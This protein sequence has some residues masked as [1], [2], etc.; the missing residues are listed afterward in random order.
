MDACNYNKTP[1]T[2]W[3]LWLLS[4][5]ILIQLADGV[6][7]AGFRAHGEYAFH[8]FFSSTTLLLQQLAIWTA[9]F[10]GAG[11][12]FAA[13]YMLIVRIV[14]TSLL[15]ILLFRRHKTLSLGCRHANRRQL[16]NLVK[17]ALANMAI[18]IAQG[19]NIQGMVIIVGTF[20]SPLA[21]V[22]FTTLRT[23]T[24]FALQIVLSI[25]HAF[26]PEMAAAWGRNDKLV[27]V[28]LYVNN[29]KL[30]FWIALCA[31]CSLFFLGNWMVKFWTNGKVP[32]DTL[33]F[34]WL[35]LSALASVLW[36]SGLNLLKAGNH[37]L[38]ASFWYII[39]SLTAVI[40]AAI[41]LQITHQLHFSGIALVILDILMMGYLF[42]TAASFID[43]K[44]G[45][46][47]HSMLDLRTLFQEVKMM[48]VH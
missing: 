32:M 15:T 35:L 23:L 20:L 10:L 26:E 8:S 40:V 27:L 30:G 18:P 9:A 33:L 37:H 25:S 42:R 11:P 19:L 13:L 14:V 29:L 39:S 34:N 31:V 45:Y 17:P 46:V 3:I 4:A 21:V 2:H 22:T 7:H 41:L 43:L 6:N 1:D 12:V 5:S 36:Y 28:K 24:R 48:I 44:A 47:I 38:R 16:Q